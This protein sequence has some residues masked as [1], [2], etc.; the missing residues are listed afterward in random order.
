MTP[1]QP[2]GPTREPQAALRSHWAEGEHAKAWTA[3]HRWIC[4]SVGRI[5]RCKGPSDECAM[6]WY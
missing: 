2:N 4:G 6:R 3:V 5:T 1:Q